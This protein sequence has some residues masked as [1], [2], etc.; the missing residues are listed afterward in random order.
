MYILLSKRKNGFEKLQSIEKRVYGRNADEKFNRIDPHLVAYVINDYRIKGETGLFEYIQVVRV[1]NKYLK[2]ISIGGNHKEHIVSKKPI[3][4]EVIGV[5]N[6]IRSLKIEYYDI[7]FSD[8]MIDEETDYI[9]T[10][11]GYFRNLHS[12]DSC[13]YYDTALRDQINNTY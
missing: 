1:D 6:D 4:Y 10:Y 8:F 2:A 12:S 5:N 3:D 13:L 9:N 11:N 7:D